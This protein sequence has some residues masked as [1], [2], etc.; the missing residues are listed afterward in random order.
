MYKNIYFFMIFL[1][2]VR[3]KK[4]SVLF[5]SRFFEH[6]KRVSFFFRIIRT[7]R[8]LKRAFSLAS[9]FALVAQDNALRAQIVAFSVTLL[10]WFCWNQK[11]QF[12]AMRA[13]LHQDCQHIEFTFAQTIEFYLLAK[14]YIFCPFC[15]FPIF[16]ASLRSNN[17]V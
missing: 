12:Q 14:L 8:T 4:L 1:E 15:S 2:S 13:R 9:T 5:V 16:S 11:A 7:K 10:C 6:H 17:F 3:G